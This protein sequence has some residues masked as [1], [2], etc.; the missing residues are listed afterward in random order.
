MITMKNVK[1]MSQRH[2]NLNQGKDPTIQYVATTDPE[3]AYTDVDFVLA[4]IRVGKL[5]MR[6]LDEKIPLK[7]GVVGQENMWPRRHGLWF[8]KHSGCIGKH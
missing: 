8:T 6:S 2:V 1:I 7:Y 5:E 3:V 4:H